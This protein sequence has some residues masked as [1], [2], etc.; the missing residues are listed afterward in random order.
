M[1]STDTSS[2]G[3]YTFKKTSLVDQDWGKRPRVLVPQVPFSSV[4]QVPDHDT[5]GDTYVMAL[6]SR[7]ATLCLLI[8]EMRRTC[9]GSCNKKAFY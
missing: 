9:E 6:G 4:S 7:E 3:K 5:S 1:K 2:Q 8:V